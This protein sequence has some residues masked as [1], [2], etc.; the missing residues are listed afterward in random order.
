[1]T[2]YLYSLIKSYLNSYSSVPKSCWN[3]IV[4]SFINT[5][6]GGVSFFLSIYFVSTLQLNIAVAG[7]I[8][9][10][11]GFGTVVG[12]LIGGKLTDKFST[13]IV[14]ITSGGFKFQVQRSEE[15]TS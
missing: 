13:G 5:T 8:I 7:A 15:H 6:S 2:R 1:M 11:Y 14:S 3:G 12:G 10:S 4:L 9:S